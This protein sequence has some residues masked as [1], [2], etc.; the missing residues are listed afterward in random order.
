[1]RLVRSL[2]TAV[3]ALV[4]AVGCSGNGSQTGSVP[5]PDVA[6]QVRTA[7]AKTVEARTA[8]TDLDVRVVLGANAQQ[9]DVSGSGLIDFAGRNATLMLRLPGDAGISEV[10]FLG[11]VA[12]LRLPLQ[13]ALLSGGTSWVSLDVSKLLQQQFGASLGQLVPNTPTNPADVL[14]FTQGKVEDVTVVGP[15]M[16][17]GAPTTRYKATFDFKETAAQQNPGAQLAIQRL[18]QQLGV[19]KLPAELWIDHNG[20]FR[21]LMVTVMLAHSPTDAQRSPATITTTQTLSD[22]GI[23]V[24]VMA[25]PPNQVVDLGVLLSSVAPPR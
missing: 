17:A 14:E 13:L 3:V 11:G 2:G 21:K 10:R 15:D 4:V 1:M 18:I 9:F 23:P 6:Q 22:F 20:R 12:Y 7:Y 19:S 5:V 8:K 24:Q 16:V 25:P